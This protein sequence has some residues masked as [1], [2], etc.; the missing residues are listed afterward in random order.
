MVSTYTSYNL[1]MRDLTRSI[2]NVGNQPMVERE[3]AYY[4]E[5]IEKVKSM[6]EFLADDRLYR[7]AMKAH[8]LEDM[9]YA[10]AF[11]KKVLTEGIRDSDSFA[12]KLSDKRYFEFAKTYNFE[13]FGEAAT[14]F[15]TAR[16]GTVDKYL[17]QTLE[18]NAGNQNEGVRLALYFERKA[19]GI[20][21]FYQVLADPA[22]A[23]VVRTALGYPAAMAQADID[24]Q[25]QM[26]ESRLDI[27]DFQDPEKLGKFLER[28]TSLWEIE[29]P[30]QSPQSSI[31][32]LFT[33]PAEFGIS[34]DLMLA[35]A[36]L[37]R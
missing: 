12:N 28:F 16:S 14:I 18:E 9:T 36:Q 6:E 11:M 24:K 37:R 15:D 13:R 34:T 4:L 30:T 25:V 1:I 29:N 17:R 27:A 7:Y 33:Q 31:A 32:A 20:T 26:M 23:Q 2:E 8:G 22:L 21:N 5:N 3:T 10:K 35:M 19:E